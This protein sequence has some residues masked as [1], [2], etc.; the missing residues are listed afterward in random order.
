M[1]A[2]AEGDPLTTTVSTPR[3]SVDMGDV[4]TVT[5]PDPAPAPTAAVG[6]ATRL[7]GDVDCDGRI[8]VTFMPSRN[9]LKS[10]MI[11][12]L[13]PEQMVLPDAFQ[14][15]EN[16]VA[17]IDVYGLRYAAQRLDVLAFQ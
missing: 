4:E 2:F 1:A 7:A 5:D 8:C 3:M 13:Y 17:D 9:A 14:F 6:G 11:S 10:E 15:R 12:P 16:L